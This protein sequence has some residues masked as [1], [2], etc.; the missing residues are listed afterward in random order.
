MK[1]ILT[2][3]AV[4]ASLAATS[5]LSLADGRHDNAPP[6]PA[7]DKIHGDLSVM[8]L[9]SGGPIATPV[10][11]AS[12]GYM[13]FTDGNPNPR[14][15]MDLGGGTYQRIAQS[16][17][18]IADVDMILL[19]HLHADHTGD[20][21]PVIK[22]IYFHN[23]LKGQIRTKPVKIYG[24][25]AT[26]YKGDAG[27][28]FPN[29][30][31]TIQYPATSDY[32]DEHY[33]VEKNGVERYLNAFVPAITN[34]HGTFSYEVHDLKSG[35]KADSNPQP[36]VVY[37]EKKG[38]NGLKITSMPVNH[39]PVP[40]L[41][42]RIE[43][44]GHV[45]VYSG[46]TSSV[47]DNMITIARNADLLIYDTAITK[48]LPTVPVFHALHTPPE[49]IGQV[50][51]AANVKKLVLSHITPVTEPRIDEVKAAIV[52]NGFGGKI[53]EAADL[54]VYNLGDRHHH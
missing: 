14:L 26:A 53:R 32:V 34:T 35:W 51:A 3:M 20:L 47:S 43:Y 7:I 6:K 24:P 39:G 18:N 31:G 17:T 44:K 16:G 9:G 27:T 10:G 33:S 50:A 29:S 12:A 41:A 36:Q 11:R 4:V 30:N 40:A 22:T 49:R 28:V 42:Y 37:D 52:A 19:S 46:D 13:I 38:R 25:A 45:V 21:T 2:T 5:P 15:I 23:N 48:D 8:V 1:K 54:Q